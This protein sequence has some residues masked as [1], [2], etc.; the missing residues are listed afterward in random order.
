M[1]RVVGEESGSLEEL[2]CE[3]FGEELLVWCGASW[4]RVVITM[5]MCAISGPR[6]T[7][8]EDD[9]EEVEQQQQGYDTSSPRSSAGTFSSSGASTLSSDDCSS[10]L[11]V[12]DAEGMDSCD[13]V[14]SSAIWKRTIPKGRRCKPLSF[15]G[16]IEYDANGKQVKIYVGDEDSWHTEERSRG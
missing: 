14:D 2:F 16:I 9:E 15:S 6:V 3:E 8:R 12:M 5:G 11:D 4:E 1:R 7:S 10:T 13:Q